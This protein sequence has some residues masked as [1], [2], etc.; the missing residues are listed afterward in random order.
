MT[1]SS[2]SGAA[3]SEPP[4]ESAAPP[5]TGK[6]R[7]HWWQFWRKPEPDEVNFTWPTKKDLADELIATREIAVSA[8]INA[9]IQ[10]SRVSQVVEFMMRVL[11]KR[12]EAAKN[13]AGAHLLQ[14]GS[15]GISAAVATLTGGALLGSKGSI[16]GGTA[17]WIGLIATVFGLLAG[18][19][20]AARPGDAYV[21]DL[22]RKSG[23]EQLFWDVRV[24]GLAQ[25][26]GMEASEYAA[27]MNEFAQRFET[28]MSTSPETS[29]SKS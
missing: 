12:Q 28:I 19:I 23:Y 1:T 7:R 20:A 11:V 4:A 18:A 14:R 3:E 13:T 10:D 6:G 17:F 24:F 9:G 26:P 21:A 8:G 15:A 2:T 29:T 27:K 22:A 5:V 25:M 16:H